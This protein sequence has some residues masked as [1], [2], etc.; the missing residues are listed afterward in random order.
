M[1]AFTVHICSIMQ[2]F[3][4]SSTHLAMLRS[5]VFLFSSDILQPRILC[6]N[7]K[8]SIKI[9]D[10]APADFN[11]NLKRTHFTIFRLTEWCIF[12]E[13]SIKICYIYKFYH[14]L[15]NGIWLEKYIFSVGLIIESEGKQELLPHGKPI[16][17][18]PRTW[19]LALPD[20]SFYHPY[21]LSIYFMLVS[22]NMH[23]KLAE[24]LPI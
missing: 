2:Q 9:Y 16:L 8:H 1:H 21:D 3:F 6:L 14:S 17:K 4:I 7:Y 11:I 13:S 24:S 5:D 15:N 18:S 12:L 19:T 23:T 22:F 10:I 20:G